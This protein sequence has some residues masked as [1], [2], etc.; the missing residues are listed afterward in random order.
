MKHNLLHNVEVS[1]CR[2]APPDGWLQVVGAAWDEQQQ[3][4]SLQGNRR[5]RAAAAGAAA[6]G[7]ASGSQQQQQPEQLGTFKALV[8][9]DSLAA[10][11]GAHLAAVTS[12]R[13]PPYC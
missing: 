1:K 8:V 9:A 6:T 2:S 11:P 10:M 12:Y 13:Y 7:E 5:G 4:W 3:R